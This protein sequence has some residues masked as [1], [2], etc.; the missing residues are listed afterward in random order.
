MSERV[1][2][3][4]GAG[5]GGRNHPKEGTLGSP[6]APT[7]LWINGVSPGEAT[8]DEVE[9]F[10]ASGRAAFGA[11][12]AGGAWGEKWPGVIDDAWLFRGELSG[13]QVERLASGE[14]LPTALP[15]AGS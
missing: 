11:R 6:A 8:L 2:I 9:M 5:P 15:G 14:D 12:L 4:G 10:T 13:A 1:L 7:P 3:T